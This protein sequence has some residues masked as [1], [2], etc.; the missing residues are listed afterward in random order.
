MC[1]QAEDIDKD[2]SD[3]GRVIR[4]KG[5]IE[6]DGGVGIGQ[7]IRDASEGSEKMTETVGLRQRAIGIYNDN[8]GLELIR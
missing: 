5:L 4:A 8:R 6:N 2:N 7:D 3:V 1:L